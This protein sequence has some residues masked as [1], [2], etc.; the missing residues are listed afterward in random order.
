MT[1][2]MDADAIEELREQQLHPEV[3]MKGTNIDRHCKRIVPMQV[4]SLGISKTGT[5][6]A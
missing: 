5:S 1:A 6:C 4:L 2:K 3:Y